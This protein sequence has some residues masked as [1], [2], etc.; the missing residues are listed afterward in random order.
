MY[1]VIHFLGMEISSW[2]LMVT[3]G[4]L[5]ALFITNALAIKRKFSFKL[6]RLLIINFLITIIIALFGAMLFQAFYDFIK[7][8]GEFNLFGS[9]LT[10]YGGFIFGVLAF[11]GV[12]FYGSR[13]IGIGNEAKEK[14]SDIADIAACVIPMAHG[15]GRIGCFLAGCCHGAPTK[16]WY[17]V[18]MYTPTGYQK[19]VP[20]Q[21]YEAIVLFAIAGVLFWLFFKG[22]EMNKKNVPLLPLYT[23]GYGV[24]R[25][26]IEY[27]RTDDRGSLPVLTFLSPS[28][29]TAIILIIAGVA[30][31]WVWYQW[32]K[33]KSDEVRAETPM[34]SDEQNEK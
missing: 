15:F 8:G 31:L 6:Q 34:A 23:I 21:L 9:G 14:F 17:G 22:S 28:Q 12:W 2:T 10:F 3:I 20:V 27:A 19:V 32:K 7:Y 18:M 33:K 16:A 30:Y 4:L 1:P 13:I 25:F 5:A 11:L 24:W 29:L 26:F